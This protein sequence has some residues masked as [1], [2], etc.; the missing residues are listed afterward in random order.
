MKGKRKLK[1]CKRKSIFNVT[2]DREYD[3]YHRSQYYA[4]FVVVKIKEERKYDIPFAHCNSKLIADNAQLVTPM[5]WTFQTT[6]K[7]P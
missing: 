3:L 1:L 4:K 7:T 2:I 6:N 5:L